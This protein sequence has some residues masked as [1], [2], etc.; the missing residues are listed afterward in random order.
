MRIA[1]ISN[2]RIPSST[3]NSIQAMKVCDALVECGHRVRLIVPAEAEPAPWDLLSQVYGL[4]HRFGLDWLPSRRGFRRTDFIWSSYEAARKDEA[5]VIYTWLPQSAALAGWLGQRVIL[6]MHADVAGRFGAWWLRQAWHSPR[7]RLLVTTAALR[8]ALERS[9]G[10]HFPDARVQIAP[11]G[12]DL[13]RYAEL[14]DPDKARARLGLEQRFTAGFTGHFYAGRGIDLLFALAQA[15]PQISFLWVGGTADKVAEWRERLS[16]ANQENVTLVGFVENS[17][18]PLYQAASDVLL[19]PYAREIASSSGQEIAEIINPMKMF[20]YMAARRPIISADLPAI[21][22]VLNEAN[23]VLCPP[24]DMEAWKI[25]LLA[26]A[27]DPGRRAALSER[28][29]LEVE[30]HTWQ[31]RAERALEGLNR[32]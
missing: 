32:S 28:A 29:R 27:D 18:L 4:Q 11:N 30:S 26:L 12:V 31:R 15:L 8:R 25:A 14:P 20:E 24:E 17:R 23:A 3:A 2:S 9:T 1:A 5:E 21:R 19:M 16:V 10:M 7:M 22:E 13:N 6:E